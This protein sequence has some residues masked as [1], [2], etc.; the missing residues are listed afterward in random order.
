MLVRELGPRFALHGTEG[1]FVKFGLDP[2]EEALRRGESPAHNPQW[3]SEPPAHWGT[4]NTQIGGLHVRGQVETLR[5]DYR[6]YYQNIYE[7]IAGQAAL[8]VTPEEACHTMR[9]LECAVQ[10]AAQQRT[11]PFAQN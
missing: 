5:G 11:L 2:Q 10:S 9:L 1:S 6:A 4:L 7:A 8:A 3:G